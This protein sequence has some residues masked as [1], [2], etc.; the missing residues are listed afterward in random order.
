MVL[1]LGGCST[2]KNTVLT[3]SYHNLTAHYNVYFNGNESYKKGIKKL[4]AGLQD[5]YLEILSIFPPVGKVGESPVNAEMEKA[6]KKGSKLITFHS[7]TAKPNYKK[8]IKNERQKEF[9]NKKEYNNWVDDAYLLIGKSHFNN[10]NL[11][12][13]EETFRHVIQN[14]PTE[15]TRFEATVWLART[16]VEENELTQARLLLEE[17]TV[18]TT[19]PKRQKSFLYAT[20]ADCY[21]RLKNLPLAAENL[22][23]A[24]TFER[25]KATKMRYYYILAQLY[26]RI[27]D[28]GKS[29]ECYDKVIKGNPNYTMTFNATISRAAVTGESNT[30][31]VRNQ[32]NK[33]LRDKKNNEYKDQ[34]Y[35]ALG[36]LDMQANKKQDAMTNY[37]LS[38]KV[39][40]TNIRQKV[41]AYVAMADVY[42]TDREYVS[43]SACYDSAMLSIDEKFP[44]YNEVAAR[45][46]SLGALVKQL[47]KAHFEDSTQRIAAMRESERNAFIDNIIK[48]VVEDE[49]NARAEELAEQERLS[50]MGTDYYQNQQFSQQISGGK[51]YFYN[52]ASKSFGQSEFA[53]KWGRRVLEDN[54]RR[55]NKAASMGVASDTEDDDSQTNADGSPSDKKGKTKLSNKTREY[56]VRNLPLTDSARKA[57]DVKLQEALF[58]AGMVYRNSLKE[59]LKAIEQFETLN[60]RYENYALKLETLNQL[61]ELNREVNNLQMMELYKRI[62]L[63]NYP[64]SVYASIIGDPNYVQRMREKEL[65]VNQHY[66]ET[67]QAYVAGNMNDVIARA[68]TVLSTNDNNPHRSRY[69]LLNA[70]ALAKLNGIETFRAEL[71]KVKENYKGS[72]EAKKAQE[73]ITS[74]DTKQPEFKQVEIQK[75]ADITYLATL[76]EQHVFVWFIPTGEGSANQLNFNIVNYNLD[77]YSST[78]VN[79]T[80][81]DLSTVGK[82][83]IVGKFNAGI[84]ALNYFDNIGKAPNITID[85][86]IKEPIRF[87]ITPANLEKLQQDGDVGAY[88]AFFRKN[89]NR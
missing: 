79:V 21:I 63:A 36:N 43:A 32:L 49:E 1:G 87:I 73:I 88:M 25:K 59:P 53:R 57:S 48:K 40:T 26:Q 82:M 10:Y 24:I 4:N 14:F 66:T 65:A 64:N 13:A 71:T 68:A 15:K 51:W 29:S 38:A 52:P 19:F 75:K 85:T 61:Y 28:N 86:D 89:Y 33:L 67:Y 31:S 45:S 22:E 11:N 39:S 55:K 62:I 16:L 56:Y 46:K 8:G 18:S 5:D 37:S 84:E 9:Y 42:Y 80:T 34:I 17:T 7:I 60:K 6:I 54:W 76:T 72:E 77:T 74:I 41:R 12:M 69:A 23:K 83:V 47:N 2:K 35:F 70:M 50:N 20:F 58:N 44:N 78:S 27:G 30:E 81:L 3:R